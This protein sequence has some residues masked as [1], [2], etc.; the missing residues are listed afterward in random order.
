MS[1]HVVARPG[2]GPA[3]AAPAQARPTHV[4]PVPGESE[5][6]FAAL[7]GRELIVLGKKWIVEVFSVCALGGC[8]YVQLSLQSNQQFMVTLRVASGTDIRQ[9][10]P[11]LLTWLAHP[12]SSGEIIDI[13]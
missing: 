13:A 12:S 9:L 7:D 4:E 8:R 3:Q 1:L 11:R 5:S 2:F 10:I 6:L